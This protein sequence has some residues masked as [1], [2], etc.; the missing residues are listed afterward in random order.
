M[1]NGRTAKTLMAERNTPVLFSKSQKGHS[2][3]MPGEGKAH[4]NKVYIEDLRLFTEEYVST[5]QFRLESGGW[6]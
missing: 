4:M 5:E 2:R 3:L 6:W 1:F